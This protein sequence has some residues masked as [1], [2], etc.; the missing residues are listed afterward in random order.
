MSNIEFT[1]KIM[2]LGGL[3]E[4][5]KNTYCIEHNDE[6]ILIDA[7]I[8]FAGKN[9]LGVEIIIPDYD[10]LVQNA[11]KIKALFITHGHED[12][13]GGIPFLLQKINI[14]NIYAPPLASDLIKLKLKKNKVKKKWKLNEYKETDV[15]KTK[16]FEVSFFQVTHSIPNSFGIFVKTPNGTVLTT[17]DF[18]IDLTPLGKKTNFERI[19]KICKQGVTLMLSDSTNS[20]INQLNFTEREVIENIKNFIIHQNKRILI[21]TFA[22]NVDRIYEVI[23][24]AQEAKRKI[25]VLGITIKNIIDIVRARKYL[26]LKKGTFIESNEIEKYPPEK[27][28]VICTGSQGEEL[29]AVSKIADNIHKNIK[30]GEKDIL[31]FSSRAIPGNHYRLEN[32]INKLRKKKIQVELDSPFN[33]IH[34]SGHANQEEQKL[35]ITLLKP[36]YFMPIH[37]EY[38]ML[39]IHGKT[40][41]KVGI[42]EKNVFVCKNG[43]QLMM[44]NG[45]IQKKEMPEIRA[46]YIG[47]DKS[48][49]EDFQI[50][51]NRQMMMKNGI[52]GISINISETTKKIIKSP[53]IISRG[54]FTLKK[55]SHFYRELEKIVLENG[56]M[57]LNTQAFEHKKLENI[58][59]NK[60]GDF[61]YKE[62]KILPLIAVNLISTNIH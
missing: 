37:G 30:A 31:I 49:E 62:K 33:R 22:S 12:H 3:S 41:E 11:S 6:I 18:K 1:T 39:R 60:V 13:I 59:I 35:M 21:A 53:I 46:V 45:I 5:G 4:V 50:L 54:C 23:M 20:E 19:Q 2:A 47:E 32:L 55:Q 7:G 38:R 10:Y 43:D 61:V 15:I 52:I 34:T 42:P 8:K 40:A 24:V 57:F 27:V 25:A 26:E 48:S 56:A 16:Y 29:S 14:P 51:N 36:K 17:G 58:I 28:I 9:L 44:K